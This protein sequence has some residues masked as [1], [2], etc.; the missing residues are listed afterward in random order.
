MGWVRWGSSP[1]AGGGTLRSGLEVSCAV[2]TTPY[3]TD[4][5]TWDLAAICLSGLPPRC[6]RS[7]YISGSQS[8]SHHKSSSSDKRRSQSSTVGGFRSGQWWGPLACVACVDS[9]CRDMITVIR[10]TCLQRH[11][12]VLIRKGHQ[13]KPNTRTKGSSLHS[14]F[15]SFLWFSHNG[16]F[17]RSP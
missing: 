11:L 8:L 6:A 7:V 1:G 10:V 9:V 12:P 4:Y 3:C 2:Y 14:L 17:V 16:S 13:G 15:A 5:D